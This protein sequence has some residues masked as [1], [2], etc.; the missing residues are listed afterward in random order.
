[1]MRSFRFPCTQPTVERFEHFGPARGVK[2]NLSQ[3]VRRLLRARGDKKLNVVTVQKHLGS[4]DGGAALLR[5]LI[6]DRAGPI[7]A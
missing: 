2:G 4:R 7:A 1:M 6:T 3:D 5:A